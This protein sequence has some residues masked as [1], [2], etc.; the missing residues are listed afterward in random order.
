MNKSI[1]ADSTLLLVVFIWGATF[2]VVQDAISF[3]SP[4]SFN[5]VRF[6]IG[7]LILCSFYLMFVKNRKNHFTMKSILAGISIG[8]WLCLGYGFQTFGLLYTS[9]GKAGFIT[10]LSVVLVPLLSYFL[11]KQTLQMNVIIGVI[12]A[13]F[14]L[15][16]IT[17]L[18]STSFG[19]GDFLVLLCAMSFA[20]HIIVTG[21]YAKQYHAMPLTLIQILTVAIISFICSL[22]FEEPAEMYHI[23][24]LL[25]KEVFIGILIT[26]IF[27]TAFAFLAQTYFQAYT[28]PARVALIFSLEPVFAAL[29]SYFMIG[30]TFTTSM[31]FGCCL[32][33][34][35]I[36]LS[37]IPF[38]TKKNEQFNS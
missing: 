22:L 9:P 12:C 23:N 32:I 38:K 21:K 24:V 5:A 18:Q 10:G 15:Y 29:T 35:G 1:L 37:E 27:A 13:T 8:I 3:L 2:V 31:L 6:F 4:F 28:T 19:K 14:G 7:F 26:A 33:F 11:L 16:M 30:E 36:I 17:M 20:M 25:Q 34:A